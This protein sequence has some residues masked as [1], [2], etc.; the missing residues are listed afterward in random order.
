[1]SLEMLAKSPIFSRLSGQ[2][3]DAVHATMREHR[4]RANQTLCSEGDSG[5]CLFVITEGAVAV[6]RGPDKT[7]LATL[8]PG[9]VVGEMA[10]M[11]ACPRTA[12]VV[13][14]KD[15]VTYELTR[16]MLDVLRSN[17]PKLASAIIGGIIDCL[18]SRI[19]RVHE[20]IAVLEGARTAAG[21]TLPAAPRRALTQ[22]ARPRPRPLQE[23]LDLSTIPELAGLSPSS[24]R[25]L[26]EVAP[27]LV[28][29]DGGELCVEGDR[30]NSCF[31]LVT[32]E[33]HVIKR[34]REGPKVIAKIG[35]GDMIGQ[36]ALVDR[37]NRTATVRATGRVVALEFLREDFE[38]LLAE[39]NPV[40]L[41]FQ[42]HCAVAAVRQLTSAD[43]WLVETSVKARQRRA[44]PAPPNKKNV[45]FL[46]Q[47]M[48]RVTA[49]DRI[50]REI[51]KAEA[52][53]PPVQTHSEPEYVEIYVHAAL[54]ESALAL[55]D[56]DNVT[57]ET[58]TGQLSASEAKSRYPR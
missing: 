2:E 53:P 52:E 57:F 34:L 41:H 30:G 9:D 54:D 46:T 6:Y 43:K 49:E 16:L 1:M 3:L 23:A 29:E 26:A 25:L 5:D 35:R 18:T 38:R 55:D 12:T 56:L 32:G 51:A 14:L 15:S 22:S 50:A 24:M 13:A 36:L 19:R 8:R 40:A 31:L 11:D 17:A 10:V 48:K 39:A 42:N 28:W 7:I 58:P 33:V 21:P 45:A 4:L 47:G 37:G 44:M 20:R 27:P